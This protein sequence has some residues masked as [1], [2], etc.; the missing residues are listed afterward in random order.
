L[1]EQRKV[2]EVHWSEHL[3]LSASSSRAG[4]NRLAATLPMTASW[5][6]RNE[7]YRGICSGDSECRR[8]REHHSILADTG[9]ASLPV[10]TF[11][12][13]PTRQAGSAYQVSVPV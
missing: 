2:P 9:A 11:S 4:C 10:S 1:P 6:F 7:Q 5:V 3:L 12:V 8:E 13:R